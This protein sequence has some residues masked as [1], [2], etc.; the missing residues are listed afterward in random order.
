MKEKLK[1]VLDKFNESK[2][3][4]YIMIIIIAIVLIIAGYLI[5]QQYSESKKNPINPDIYNQT[6][7]F[8][9][10]DENKQDDKV[11]ENDA[12][13]LSSSLPVITKGKKVGLA[14]MKDVDNSDLFVSVSE[15]LKNIDKINI[16]TDTVV[17]LDISSLDSNLKNSINDIN[18]IIFDKEGKVLFDRKISVV[19]DRITLAVD[20]LDK[21][22]VYYTVVNVY[23]N[24][25][26]NKGYI[27]KF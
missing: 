26:T 22:E 11:N 19:Y 18:A 13:E 14:L 23:L 17:S 12:S 16:T 4:S 1:N 9:D 21:S 15:L 25:G 8:S 5:Y 3:A 6:D 2:Y 10:K 27:F 20:E 24:D 7:V